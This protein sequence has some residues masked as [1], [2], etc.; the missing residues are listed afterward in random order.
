[1]TSTFTPETFTHYLRSSVAHNTTQLDA[2]DAKTGWTPDWSDVIN[3][4]AV[5]EVHATVLRWV[6]NG[7]DIAEVKS[8][9]LEHVMN[10][11]RN[12]VRSTNPIDTY[13]EQ[14]LNAAR[15]ALLETLP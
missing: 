1:M 12:P 13:R 11:A 4:N 10:A 8:A 5:T 3:R 14:C 2:F 7:R 15:V 9:L 6:D